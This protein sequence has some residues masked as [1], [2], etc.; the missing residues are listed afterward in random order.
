MAQGVDNPGSLISVCL[1]PKGVSL[2]AALCCP[3]PCL[4]DQTLRKEG[5]VM[6]DEDFLI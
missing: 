4:S 5:E 2:V 6:R 1:W 3:D